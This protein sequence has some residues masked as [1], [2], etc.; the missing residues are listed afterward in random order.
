M[1]VRVQSSGTVVC[2]DCGITLE[3]IRD[4]FEPPGTFYHPMDAWWANMLPKLESSKTC[5][6]QGKKFR[7]QILDN[8]KTSQDKN[9][10][11]A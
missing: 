3:K 5:P 8:P 9:Y 10:R 4:E 11:R 2:E 6:N 1:V 7:F